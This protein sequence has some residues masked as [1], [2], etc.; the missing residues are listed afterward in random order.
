MMVSLLAVSLGCHWLGSSLFSRAHR[1]QWG[2]G[3]CDGQPGGRAPALTVA[4]G[5]GPGATWA[6]GRRHTRPRQ[7]TGPGP[8]PQVSHQGLPSFSK[9]LQMPSNHLKDPCSF[10][11]E[12]TTVPNIPV[13]PPGAQLCTQ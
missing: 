8:R 6:E 11:K 5:L 7:V 9:L 3:P 4:R 13:F 10:P 2:G 12:L 1:S